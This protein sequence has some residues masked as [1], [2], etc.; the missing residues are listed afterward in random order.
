MHIDNRHDSVLREKKNR[1]KPNNLNSKRWK[2]HKNESK[3]SSPN[4]NKYWRDY[5]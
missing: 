2:K 4:D 3:K 5:T 1:N